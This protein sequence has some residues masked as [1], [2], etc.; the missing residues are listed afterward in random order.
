[1]GRNNFIAQPSEQK[2]V[3]VVGRRG[4]R[5]TFQ[6]MNEPAAVADRFA[7]ALR[8]IKVHASTVRATTI[9]ARRAADRN[10]EL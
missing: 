8:R 1:L 2:P 6:R 9:N 7:P 10:R 5:R 3:F 4:L